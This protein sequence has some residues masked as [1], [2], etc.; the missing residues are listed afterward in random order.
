MSNFVLKIKNDKLKK[1]LAKLKYF[2]NEINKKKYNKLFRR[3]LLYLLLYF[4]IKRNEKG[5]QQ[6]P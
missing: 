6:K 1:K 5:Y 3:N 4:I 2:L